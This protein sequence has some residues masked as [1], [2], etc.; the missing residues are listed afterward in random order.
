MSSPREGAR[1]GGGAGQMARAKK[2]C[3][4][5]QDSHTRTGTA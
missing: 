1:K 5:D 2:M 3:H 4:G